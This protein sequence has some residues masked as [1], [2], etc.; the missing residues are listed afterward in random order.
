MKLPAFDYVSPASLGEALAVLRANEDAKL[1]S[2]GQSLMPMLAFRLLAP[3]LLVD[4]RSIP[5]LADIGIDAQGVHL[6][7][8]VRWRD[9]LDNDALA[10]AHPLLRRAVSHVAHYQIRNRGTVGGSLA[11]ADPAAELPAVAIACEAMV[12]IVGESGVRRIP[13]GDFFTGAL[14]TVLGTDE[15]V[16]ALH[17]P[18]WPTGRLWGFQEFSRRSGDFALAGICAFCDLEHGIAT[19]SHIA[20]F[21]AGDLAVRLAEA[22]AALDGAPLDADSIANVAAIAGRTAEVNDDIHAGA[23]YRRAL[24]QVMTERALSD[25]FALRQEH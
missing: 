9:I 11:H 19:N 2:G 18:L 24:V 3:K 4:L 25:A 13:V 6:G 12:E 16:T 23:A 1:I 5:D 15:I 14:G 21:G 17:L 8:R 20:V 10:M 22:E 7:A